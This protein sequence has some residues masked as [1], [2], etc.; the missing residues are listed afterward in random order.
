M[1]AFVSV[2]VP[3][4]AP[5]EDL[6]SFPPTA[7]PHLTLRFF[8]DLPEELAAPVQEAVRSAARAAAP[9]SIGLRGI[10]AFPGPERPR[11]V[12][13]GITPGQPELQELARTLDAELA[14]RGVPGEPSREL[15]PHLTLFRVRRA[16]DLERFHRL[17]Q[18]LDDRLLA[19]GTVTELHW[20]RS[21][22]TPSGPI[23]RVLLAAH[24]GRGP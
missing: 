5:G 6:P 12:W 14:A 1:R 11:V 13:I 17:S 8:G 2:P 4:L 21:E 24:L 16:A 20:Q 18:R 3:P 19:E 22:L 23:H 7:P 9:F 10:G 15:V